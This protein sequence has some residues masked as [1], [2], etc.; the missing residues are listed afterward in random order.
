M[1][2]TKMP[3]GYG[4]IESEIMQMEGLSIKAKGLYAYLSSCTGGKECDL[5]KIEIIA[6]D[7]VIS[8]SAVKKYLNEL[9]SFGIINDEVVRE[10]M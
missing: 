3:K 7:L 9:L 2:Y 6:T 4:I 10:V 1:R 5:P 8:K